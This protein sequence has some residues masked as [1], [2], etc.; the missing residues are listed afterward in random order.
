VGSEPSGNDSRLLERTVVRPLVVD[1]DGTIT[2]EDRAVDPR[3]F[4]VLRE[5]PAPVVIATGKAFPYPVGLC[6]FCG[7]P[8]RVIAENGGVVCIDGQVTIDGDREGA[9]AV[10]ESYVAQGYD[11]G[12]DDADLANRWRETEVIVRRESPLEPLE[13][14]AREHGLVVVDTGFAYHVKAPEVDKGRGLTLAGAQLGI[15]P[16]EFV[17]I[18]DSVNDAETFA[19]AGDSYAVANADDV[20]REAATVVTDAAYAEGFLE[21][22][23]AIEAAE[24]GKTDERADH[25]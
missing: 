20:A 5:W 2:D 13:A 6:E 8:V 19:I 12:W 10:L 15:D 25:D 22:I 23:A 14:L 1:I 11:P 21:A 4:S 3:A 16:A 17:A 7:L 9:G 18:G 24:A